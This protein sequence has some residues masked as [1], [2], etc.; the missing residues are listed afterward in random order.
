[1]AIASDIIQ[2]AYRESNL[3]P[4]GQTP[5]ANQTAEALPLLNGLITSVVGNEAGQGLE[6]ITI[7]GDFDQSHLIT[8]YI[9]DNVRLIFYSEEGSLLLGLD[10]YPKEGQRF[11]MVDT[12]GAMSTNTVTID[13][14]GRKIEGGPDVTLSTDNMYRQWMYRADSGDWV[15]ISELVADDAFPFPVEFE[16]FFVTALAMRINP[17]FSQQVTAETMNAMQRLRSQLRARYSQTTKVESDLKNYGLASDKWRT[18]TDF[19]TGSSY[20]LSPYLPD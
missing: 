4:I 11:A 18:N 12:S 9:P 15:R 3:I 19:S 6:D 8:E 14:N 5:T 13:G 2:R 17:R 1:M 20:T 10:P 7:G 16:D